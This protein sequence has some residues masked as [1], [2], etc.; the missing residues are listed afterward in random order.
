M[1]SVGSCI[2]THTHALRQTQQQSELEKERDG[3]EHRDLPG[4]MYYPGE[5]EQEKGLVGEGR[6]VERRDTKRRA[7]WKVKK[8][9]ECIEACLCHRWRGDRGG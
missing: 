1:C 6:N 9:R 4:D 8:T 3:D 7:K 2:D 5:G